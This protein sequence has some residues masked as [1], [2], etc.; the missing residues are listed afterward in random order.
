LSERTIFEVARAGAERLRVAGI[1]T[2][3]LDAEVLMRHLLNQTQ[4]E[5]FLHR[6]EPIAESTRQEFDALIDQRIERISV[7]YLVGEREF[8]GLTFRVGPGV[9][10]PR[11]ETESMV[12]AVVGWLVYNNRM[13]ARVVDVGTGSG[14]IAIS[15]CHH[16]PREHLEEVVAIDNS[17]RALIWARENL[18]TLGSMN[19]P[20]RFVLGHLLDDV[21]GPVDV[22]LANLPYLKPEQVEG[23]PDLASE[24]VEALVSG[25]EGLDLIRELL[26]D[27]GRVLA[28]DGMAMLEIDP[29]QAATLLAEASALFPEARVFI[30]QDLSNRDRFLSIDRGEPM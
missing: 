13:R 30:E 8:M 4:V 20:V 1:E 2:P 25:P 10:V 16:V 18:A 5:Y 21:E 9:L 29:S 27:L 22:I 24:P 28:A 23:N 11:P 7:A 6:N 3:E 14:A 12:L 15:V 17:P 26:A 19:V